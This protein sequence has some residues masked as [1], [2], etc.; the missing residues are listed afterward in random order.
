MKVGLILEDLKDAQKWLFQVLESSFPGINIE[1]AETIEEAEEI[2]TTLKPDIALI[3]LNLPDGSGVSILQLIANIHQDCIS[4]VTTIYDDDDALFSALSA[5]AQGYLLKEEKKDKLIAAL[6]GISEGAPALSPQI[7]TRILNYFSSSPGE[8]NP[9]ST[10]DENAIEQL[11]QREKEVLKILTKGSS[12]KKVA[13]E[14]NIS[15]HT[16]ASHIKNIYSKLS[17]STRA[18]AVKEAFRLGVIDN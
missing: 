18:E 15:Y 9:L 4:V 1:I 8:I 12:T 7:S 16:V 5:G 2:L 6:K 13:E 14:L 3:D 10:A 17:I 11:T